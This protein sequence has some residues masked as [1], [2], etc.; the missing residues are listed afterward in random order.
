MSTTNAVD[1]GGVHVRGAWQAPGGDVRAELAV[2]TKTGQARIA[3]LDERA[4]LGLMD[5]CVEALKALTVHRDVTA[6]AAGT[7]K[8]NA[9]DFTDCNDRCYG[10]PCVHRWPSTYRGP[11]STVI[12]GPSGSRIEPR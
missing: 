10:E 11:S 1:L 3:Q 4:L 7:L 8:R 5:Q 2:Y 12:E 9:D 6:R